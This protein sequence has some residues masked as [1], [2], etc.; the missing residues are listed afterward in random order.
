MG[1]KSWKR[2]KK[3]AGTLPT[4][5]AQLEP[6]LRKYERLVIQDRVDISTQ[7]KDA[8][9]IYN[10]FH[11]LNRAQ[12]WGRTGMGRDCIEL[13]VCFANCVCKDTLLF[14]YLFKQGVP[15]SH[16]AARPSLWKKCKSMKG[17][18]CCKRLRLIEER[19]CNEKIIDFKSCS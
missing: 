6:L 19:N 14:V 17:T 13:C 11:Q 7:L 2:W 18:A 16:V 12:E 3:F 9:K 4:V 8:L 15:D 10:Y 5:R 1:K